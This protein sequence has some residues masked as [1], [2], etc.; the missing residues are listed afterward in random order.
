MLVVCATVLDSF[1][2]N[3][4]NS[5]TLWEPRLWLVVTKNS[6]YV[7]NCVPETYNVAK[8]HSTVDAQVAKRKPS[9]AKLSPRI[10]NPLR[11]DVGLAHTILNVVVPAIGHLS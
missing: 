6:D 4:A 3:F 1:R 8:L 5:V 9:V 2:M 7:S 10:R 11:P